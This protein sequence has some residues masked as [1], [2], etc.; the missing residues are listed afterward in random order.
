MVLKG[1][2]SEDVDIKRIATSIAFSPKSS[3]LINKTIRLAKRLKA[4]PFFVHVGEETAEKKEMLHNIFKQLNYNLSDYKLFWR[5]GDP[6]TEV[7]EFSEE[8]N[9]DLLIAGAL[10]KENILK[11]YLGSIARGISRKS[12]C[13]VLMLTG[14][15]EH[16]PTFT[17]IVVEANETQNS[18]AV[19]LANNFALLCGAS[20][21]TLVKEIYNPTMAFSMA[22]GSTEVESNNMREA[23][24]TEDQQVIE[25][26]CKECDED[27]LN[28]KTVTVEGKPGFALSKYAREKNA[29]LLVVNAPQRSLNLIDRIFTHDIEYIL[30]DLP[31][32]LLI[33]KP[34]E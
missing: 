15:D 28:I 27:K 8:Q 26:L 19:K 5:N 3:Y 10:S 4:E 17:K 12:N 23:I 31:C 21:L 6:V 1:N 7:I 11:F 32:S 34:R 9:I 25:N 33:A 29:D 30:A 20:N 14:K 2:L 22:D 18:F 24:L 16:Q 13:S